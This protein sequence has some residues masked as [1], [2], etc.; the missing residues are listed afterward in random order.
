MALNNCLKLFTCA[1]E[2]NG[3]KFAYVHVAVAY[4]IMIDEGI[5]NFFSDVVFE[6][7]GR[8]LTSVQGLSDWLDSAYSYLAMVNYP[9][10][11]NFLMP[12]PGH[13]IR[14]VSLDMYDLELVL[15]IA[16]TIHGFLHIRS[17]SYFS[18]CSSMDILFSFVL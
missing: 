17:Q 18:N 7:L 8:E 4:Y 1:S 16:Q 3:R 13:P 11:S 15:W 12:L 10:P 9:Y 5:Y 14:E 2:N 6:T